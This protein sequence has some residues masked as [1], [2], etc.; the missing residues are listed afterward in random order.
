MFATLIKCEVPYVKPHTLPLSCLSLY[1]E[2]S[3]MS[4]FQPPETFSNVSSTPSFRDD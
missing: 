1:S 3:N 4:N 2:T